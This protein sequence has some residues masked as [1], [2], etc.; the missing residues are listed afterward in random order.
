MHHTPYLFY[1]LAS[2]IKEV[3]LVTKYNAPD[4]SSYYHVKFNTYCISFSNVKIF[5]KCTFFFFSKKFFIVRESKS[6]KN[7]FLEYFI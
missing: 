7:N 2:Y 5:K 4:I 1:D 6:F 3:V